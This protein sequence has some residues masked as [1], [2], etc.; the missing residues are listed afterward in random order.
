MTRSGFVAVAW[1]NGSHDPSGNGYGLK[2]SATDRDLYLERGWGSVVLYLSGKDLPVT[3][4]IDKDSLWN[5]SC[6]ELISRE[7]GAWLIHN[8]R[9]PW[10]KGKP[11]KFRVLPRGPRAFDILRADSLT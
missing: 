10:P 11:P 3:V 2:I 1:N 4:N 8:G 7:I 5:E 9:A 6:R